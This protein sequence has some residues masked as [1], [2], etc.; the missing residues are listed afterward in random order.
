MSS[1]ESAKASSPGY[2]E[3][4]VHYGQIVARLSVCLNEILKQMELTKKE[5]IW[6]QKIDGWVMIA[7]YNA[8]LIN[9]Q[10]PDLALLINWVFLNRY[11]SKHP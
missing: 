5:Y 10:D 7:F 4:T 2:S 8:Q 9:K 1:S 3:S 6:R 11:Y